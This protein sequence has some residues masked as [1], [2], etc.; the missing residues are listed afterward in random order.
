MAL[1]IL[2]V[3]FVNIQSLKYHTSSETVTPAKTLHVY[4]CGK[5]F[6]AEHIV[7][8]HIANTS[9]AFVCIVPY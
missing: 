5:G 4:A 8:E 3:S 9:L 6:Q 1:Q 2:P 7:S